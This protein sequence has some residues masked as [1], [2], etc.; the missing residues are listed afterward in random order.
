MAHCLVFCWWVV[1]AILP[2]SMGLAR[3]FFIDSG[4]YAL[5]WFKNDTAT[6]HSKRYRSSCKSALKFPGWTEFIITLSIRHLLNAVSNVN[7]DYC[8][9]RPTRSG[10]FFG[11]QILTFSPNVTNVCVGWLRIE[12]SSMFSNFLL[13]RMSTIEI[14]R[15][16]QYS[17]VVLPVVYLV[18]SEMNYKYGSLRT[19]T[20]NTSQPTI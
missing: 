7:W 16:I 19:M 1:P 18:R 14:M 13:S 20:N 11:S 3:E 15:S 4:V 2:T 5:K 9:R 17:N 8:W 10:T 6:Q 12:P